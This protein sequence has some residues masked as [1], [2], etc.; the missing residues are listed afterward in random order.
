MSLMVPR[1]YQGLDAANGQPIC[2][3][4]VS[5][6]LTDPK[7]RIPVRVVLGDQDINENT[8]DPTKSATQYPKCYKFQDD[9]IVLNI[10][11]TPGIGDT[12]ELFTHL[13][14][15]TAN[16]IIFLYTNARSTHYLPGDS[17]P[18]LM[19]VLNKVKNRPPKVDIIYNKE[20]TYC[21]DNES[22]RYLVALVP[23]NNIQFDTKYKPSYVESWKRSVEECQRLFSYITQLT[24]HKVMDTLSLNN[25]K[26]IIQLLTKPMADITKNIADNI[27]ECE[28]YMAEVHEYNESIESLQQKLY[29]PSVEIKTIP[30][31]RPKTVC[32]EGKC[33][34]RQT[35]NG[36]VHTKYNECHS[37]C[38]LN[39]SSNTIV[40][41]KGLIQCKAFNANSN[42]DLRPGEP[43]KLSRATFSN[44]HCLEC[45]HSYKKHLHLWY[46]TVAK[47]NEVI[48]QTVDSGL[49]ANQS[50]AEA[51]EQQ[52]LL[53]DQRIAELSAE[54]NTI[55][56]SMAEFMCFLAAN[57]LTPLNDA[58]GNYVKHMIANESFETPGADSPA[59]ADRLKHVLEK[60]NTDKELVKL[61]VKTTR[62]SKGS[63]ITVEEID[64]CVRKLC[65]LKHKGK[66]ISNMIDELPFDKSSDMDKS[67]PKQKKEITVLLLGQSGV[68]KSTFINAIVNYLSFETMDAANG[69]PICLMPVSFTIADPMTRMPLT[70]SLGDQD[71]AQ[72]KIKDTTTSVTQYPMCYKFEDDNIVLNI[73]D[74]PGIADTDGVDKDNENMKN[75]LDFISNYREINAFCVLLKSNDTRVSV[76][77]KYCIFELFTHL[78]KSAANN[79]LF[80]FTNCRSTH[81][82]P[83]ES[84]PLLISILEQIK[85]SPPNVEIPYNLNTTYCFDSESFRYLVA[86]SDP[87]NIQFDPKHKASYVESWEISVKECQR[88]FEY[89]IQLTPHKVMDTL[90]LNNAK[91][92]IHLLT[93]PLADIAKNIADNV[94]QCEEHSVEIN[95]FTGTIE[96][97]NN[98]LYIPS[99]DII[100]VP[101]DRPKTVCSDGE[102]CEAKIINGVTDITYTRECHSPCYLVLNTG[103]IMG[104]T[105]LLRCKAFNKESRSDRN[106]GELK[107]WWLARV[108][109]KP[110][111]K[112]KEKGAQSNECHVCGHSYEKHMQLLYETQQ[113]VTK[114]TDQAVNTQIKSVQMAA[115]LKERQLRSLDKRVAEL[116]AENKIIAQSVPKFACFLANNALTPINDAF[117]DY[118]RHL[119]ANERRG[120]ATSG[121]DSRVTT[122]RLEQMLDQYKDEKELIKSKMNEPDAGSPGSITLAEINAC[123]E[124]L[125]MLKHKGG[126]I[127]RMLDEQSRA[128]VSR[129][130]RQN[131]VDC[132]ALPNNKF[133]IAKL[134]SK[135]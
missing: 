129:H 116:N 46:E 135:K 89:I 63:V 64:E 112:R 2:L 117:E 96:E 102:C 103:D 115:D 59:T 31:D 12:E 68:G 88:L 94:K 15:S 27:N 28:R 101:L 9:N 40:G 111:E 86:T 133:S 85:K 122:E 124:R 98:K 106:R 80:L 76:M 30:L 6:T 127:S 52:I 84:G 23:P 20:T 114:V 24:P 119:I 104:N 73:I 33:C 100:T 113:R 81:Y 61:A 90:S 19:S 87:N 11:D 58:F 92:I 4:P 70:V 57:A 26:Q 79:I 95:E 22:F 45:G 121:A 5:F 78:N 41:T 71:H 62:G 131:H 125:R 14:K 99:V 69:Q 8:D 17:S 82:M 66:E 7:T 39:Y 50:A 134:F 51:K 75:I 1:K 126:E 120:L 44:K 13:N 67:P 3:I 110:S 38:Y 10:I 65:K 49:R 53:L 93:Q 72:E 108:L 34:T 130:V 83:G 97:L 36:L 29:I 77:F 48:D 118:V 42:S 16:N 91:Q 123:V 21:F 55:V 37:P 105:A 107:S 18:A 47:L 25:A 109:S 128:K 32:V 74:T 132:R 60:Y 35:L 56:Y 54:S 43:T